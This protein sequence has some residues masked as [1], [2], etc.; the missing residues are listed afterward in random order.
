MLVLMVQDNWKASLTGKDVA[1][2][3]P[4]TTQVDSLFVVYGTPRNVERTVGF[5]GK[6]P[7]IID[8]VVLEGDSIYCDSLL[9]Y[10]LDSLTV[11]TDNLRRIQYYTFTTTKL[12]TTRG[13]AV[14]QSK[15][16][17]LAT[18]G[19]PTE[20]DNIYVFADLIAGEDD[21][22]QYLCENSP[23]GIQFFFSHGIVTRIFVGRGAAC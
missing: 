7:R 5:C 18:Y 16:K 22:L 23:L 8:N 17:V 11:C 9:I 12:K 2:P 19:K 15:E 1:G 21:S 20:A 4:E 6:G 3:L 13:I 14:G 10:T